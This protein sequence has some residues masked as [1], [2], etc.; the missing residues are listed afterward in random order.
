MEDPRNEFICP[1]CGTPVTQSDHVC[2]QCGLDLNWDDAV[3]FAAVAPMQVAEIFDQTFRKF[4]AVIL[5]A[6]PLILILFVPVAALLGVGSREFYGTVGQVMQEKGADMSTEAAM[7]IVRSLGVFGLALLFALLMSMA[8]E[9]AVTRLVRYEYARDRLPW[10]E[11]FKNAFGIRYFRGL[12]VAL[13]EVVAVVGIFGIPLGLLLMTGS[14]VV[15]ALLGLLTVPLLLAIVAFLLIRWSMAFT[16][17]ACEDEGVVAALRRSWDL[18]T[19]NW[20]RVFGIL[21]LLGILANVAIGI[22]TTPVSMVALGDFYGEYFKMLGSIGHGEP[23]PAVIGRM[24][25]SMGIGV[26]ISGALNMMLLTLMRPVYT[27]VLYFDLRARNGEFAST[28]PAPP[29][30]APPAPGVG[31]HGT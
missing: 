12:G 1:E 21:V 26:G 8:G 9:L 14:G 31:S 23:D 15:I 28:A 30:G 19:G 27:T 24:L 17:V 25:S 22:L 29:S 13:I 20:W 10:T 5:R 11:A 4:G 2:P 18:L 7:A 3:L 6:L 16:V